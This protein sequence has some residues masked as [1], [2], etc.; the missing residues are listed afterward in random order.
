[1]T[2]QPGLITLEE[3]NMTKPTI[4]AIRTTDHPLTDLDTASCLLEGAM[5][6]LSVLAQ[7][8]QAGDMDECEVAALF[9][10][11]DIVGRAK[12]IGDTAHGSLLKSAGQA[13]RAA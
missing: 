5:G 2:A 3:A 13:R 10:V 7:H 12:S 4:A 8:G 9:G 1:V 11:L 6:M